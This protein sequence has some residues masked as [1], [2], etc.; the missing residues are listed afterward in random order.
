MLEPVEGLEPT[1]SC[2]QNHSPIRT[3]PNRHGHNTPFR[4]FLTRKNARHLGQGTTI[5]DVQLVRDTV[6]DTHCT[7]L[8]GGRTNNSEIARDADRIIDGQA[9]WL[10]IGW[11]DGNPQTTPMQQAWYYVPTQR[12]QA[13]THLAELAETVGNIYARQCLFQKLLEPSKRGDAWTLHGDY[14]H[15]LPSR[16]LWK[17]DCRADTPASVLI[18]TSPD[19]Y[20]ALIVLDR[21]ATAAERKCLMTAWRDKDGSDTCSA[22]AVHFIRLSG[23][24]NTKPGNEQHQVHIAMHSERTYSADKLLARCAPVHEN[25]HHPDSVSSEDWHDLLDGAA[26]WQSPRWQALA[27]RQRPQLKTLLIDRQPL[28]LSNRRTGRTDDDSWSN[29]RAVFVANVLEAYDPP[30]LDEL[31]AVAWHFRDYLGERKTDQDYQTDIDR[32]IAVYLDRLYTRRNRVYQPQ[33]TKYL[34]SRPSA[35]PARVARGR[36]GK[37][38]ELVETVWQALVARQDAPL[39]LGALASDLGMDR[40]T[41]SRILDELEADGRITERRQAGQYSGLQLTLSGVIYSA[42]QSAVSAIATPETDETPVCAIESTSTRQDLVG[43]YSLCAQAD[44]TSSPTADLAALVQEAIDA[45]G[46]RP[47]KVKPLERVIR[48]VQANGGATIDPAKIAA[49]Y[50]ACL[51]TR[52]WQQANERDAARARTLKLPDLRRQSRALATQVEAIE[53]ALKTGVEL[54]CVLTFEVN[55]RTHTTRPPK[56]PTRRYAAWVRHRAGIYAA[57]EARRQ[58]AEPVLTTHELW[59]QVDMVAYT[60]VRNELQRTKR[61]PAPVARAAFVATAEPAC[62]DAWAMIRR[63][64]QAATYCSE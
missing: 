44:H 37:H 20:Q 55:G 26:L 15:A 34:Q 45:Y 13:L 36:A 38:A 6:R 54:P 32:L 41:L 47:G 4:G 3:T 43:V 29:Q 7:A 11:I 50:H 2:L 19:K 23:G 52:R 16:L 5:A 57:E 27:T 62:S 9:G 63:L 14:A 31:R 24:R 8:P 17:D 25:T 35:A 40:R 61:G 46:T 60:Q 1:T 22:D 10:C 18:E 12:N 64:Q 56:A 53:R 48:Y 58:P 49:V 28:A 51:Q 42:Q 21:P 59:A 30:P 33:P 39:K